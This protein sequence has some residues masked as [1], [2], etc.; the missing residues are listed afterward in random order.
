MRA[1][2]IIVAFISFSFA[3]VDLQSESAFASV[4]LPLFVVLGFIALAVW[5]VGLMYK[6]GVNQRG[7]HD[8][9]GYFWDSDAGNGGC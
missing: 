5:C 6:R 9:G 1:F 2:I 4:V 8:G 3:Y 7:R